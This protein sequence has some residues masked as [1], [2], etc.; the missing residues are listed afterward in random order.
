MGEE[1][2]EAEWI[3]VPGAEAEWSGEPGLSSPLF[4]VEID[5]VF[6]KAP[7]TQS[8]YKYAIEILHIAHARGCMT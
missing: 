5:R 7:Q 4:R 3:L 6:F 1:L 2:E 8:S